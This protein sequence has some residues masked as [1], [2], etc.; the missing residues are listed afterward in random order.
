MANGEIVAKYKLAL[1]VKLLDAQVAATDGVWMDM[2]DYAEGTFEVSG[3]TVATVQLRGSNAAVRPVNTVHGTQ[4]GTDITADS[5]RDVAIL[6]RWLKA[7]ISAYTS[8]TINA[9]GMLKTTK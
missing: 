3:I 4:L 5:H 7:R 6:P 1:H 9:L 2:G 8:G